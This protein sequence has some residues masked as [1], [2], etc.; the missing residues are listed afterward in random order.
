[1]KK[2]FL[3]L[4]ALTLGLGVKAQCPMDTAVDFT[5]TDV[6]GTEIHLFD[7]L[8]QGQYVLIDF[9]F[10]TCSP[11]QQ[12]TPKI[13]QSYYAFGCNMHDVFYMEIASG[14][15][16][17]ACLNWVNNY[18]VEYPTISGVAGGTNICNQYGIS[19]YPTIIL[20]APDHSIVIKDLW[21]IS[22]AQTVINA[23]EAHGVEQHDCTDPTG[24][25]ESGLPL[26]LYPNPANDFIIIK[27]ENLGTVRI[28]NTLG[29][30][31]DE[32]ETDGTERSISTHQYPNGVY[33]VQTGETT[34]RLIIQH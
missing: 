33:F 29:Q 27:G 28:F 25:E 3:I 10:T 11:C 9:F 7:I 23:L 19:S 4:M 2:L 21:P 13:A 15:S 32:F 12:V 24:V 5:A 34:H 17:A 30:K 26:C 6:H 16:E 20:I 1:M 31:M 18:G 22:S 14:D 8:D